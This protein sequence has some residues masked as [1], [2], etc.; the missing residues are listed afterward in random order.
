[1]AG[2]LTTTDHIAQV[3]LDLFA[4]R[5]YH[6]VSIR[7][8]CKEVGIKESTVYYHYENKQAIWDALIGQMDQ[9]IQAKTSSFDHAFEGIDQVPEAAM[10][11]V[12]ASLL[13]DYFLQPF[14]HK[15]LSMLAIERMADEKADQ[16]YK[17]IA[18]EL[19]LK[20]Q[21]KV[22]EAMMRRGMIPQGDPRLLAREYHGIIFLTYQKN[23]VG[24][25][26]TPAQT[27]QACDEVYQLTADLYRKMRRDHP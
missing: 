26:F 22:F 8:I 18:F 19:P 23:C 12:A 3:A 9:L 14:V 15:I 5:G 10:C 4:Q 7:D 1:M 24:A 20:Q 17:R 11:Q 21:E 2:V 27:E 16:E 25:L 13:R 6:A